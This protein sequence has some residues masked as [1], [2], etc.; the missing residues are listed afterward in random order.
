MSEP[1][2]NGKRWRHRIMVD[3]VRRNGTFDTKAAALKWEAQQRI[4]IATPTSPWAS[5]TC[6]D[7]FRRYEIE[8]SKTKR[9]YRW[10][11]GRLA[12]MAKSPLGAVSMAEV[13]ATHISAWR[14]LRLRSV[15]GGTV[16]REMNLLSHVFSVARR[17]WKWLAS[18]PTTDV[19]RPKANP[20]RDRRVSAKEIEKICLA[21]NWRHDPAGVSPESKQQRIAIAFLFAI[22]TAM[23]A[24]E[25]CA[26]RRGD[27]QGQVARLHMTKNG[28][29]RDVPLSS[30][31]IKLW[32]MVPDGFG[33]TT[34]TL[35]AMF[36]LARKRAGV[37][38]LTFHD[39]RHEAITRLAQKLNVLDLARMVGHRDIKQLQTYYNASAEDIAR[40]L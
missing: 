11:A 38:G 31:A 40:K 12:A 8:V 13:C 36:R 1:V 17:E 25:I 10:E 26:L 28:F 39:T 32:E 15:Q 14:D 22:E 6:A 20:A 37:E 7:A 34:Q 30:R 19:S 3:G 23:R 29:P 9:G 16:T 24:G 4:S 35:D 21:L 5:K 18:S 27:V 33:I 2:R